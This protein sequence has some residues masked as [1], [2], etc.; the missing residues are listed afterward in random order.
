MIPSFML[1]QL[2]VKG[3][4]QNIKE[5]DQ[6]KG[7]SFKLRNNLGSGTIKGTLNILVDETPIEPELVSIRKGENEFSVKELETKSMPFDVGD[8]VTFIVRKEGG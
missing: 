5:G 3:S 6:I 4:L 7:Y 2:Y 8:E 1:R